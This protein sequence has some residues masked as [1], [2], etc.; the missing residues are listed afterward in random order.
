MSLVVAGC[1]CGKSSLHVCVLDSKPSNLKNFARSYKVLIFKP[2][3]EDIE[4]LLSLPVDVYAIEPTGDYSRIWVEQ[5]K[6]ADKDL[7]LVSS[8]RVRHYCEYHGLTNKADRPDAAAIAAYTLENHESEQAFLRG[9]KQRIRDLYLQLCS[10]TRSKNP[11][12]NRLGQR[13]TFEFP[14]IVKT[15]EESDRLWLNEKPPAT[16]RFIAGEPTR[17][18]Q[19]KKEELLKNTIGLGLSEQT[20]ALAKTLCS[21]ERQEYNLEVLLNEELSRDIFIPY[22]EAFKQFAVPPRLEAAILSRIYPFED[23]LGS[24]GRPRKEYIQGMT[25]KRKSGKTKRDRSEGEFKLSLGM[26]KVLV[27]S[28]GRWE[29][30]PG[31]AKYARSAL[32]LYVVQTVVKGKGKGFDQFIAPIEK[33]LRRE[34]LSPWLNA[35]IISAVAQL[36]SIPEPLAALRIHYEFQTSKGDRR[37][38]ATA[39]RFCRMLYKELVK[40][41]CRESQ[42]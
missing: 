3:R 18:G 30:K 35:D 19:K 26:G 10:T 27:Q 32:W 39:G 40:S 36:K 8:R 22:R 41:F 5:L 42:I 14:E 13:L 12:Q 33:E 4:K 11:I 21:F 16:F 2:T 38:E 20:R 9:E 29:W 7:R 28:G 34:G 17:Q 6:K 31:G 1:D 15:Y 25:T 37:I 23:F 24:D